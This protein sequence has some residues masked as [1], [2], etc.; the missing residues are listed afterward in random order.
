ML[1]FV[2]LVLSAFGSQ[3]WHSVVKSVGCLSLA[4]TETAS[5]QAT[6]EL[7]VQHRQEAVA[8]ST[9]LEIRAE[10]FSLLMFHFLH[11]QLMTEVFEECLICQNF[12][13]D[14]YVSQLK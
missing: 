8:N 11:T 12:Y 5:D 2:G 1:V 7:N 4:L 10:I 6:A 9:L 14:F 13:F 3:R